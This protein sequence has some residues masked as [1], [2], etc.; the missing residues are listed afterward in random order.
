MTAAT[1]AVGT[2]QT[3]YDVRCSVALGSKADIIGSLSCA[4]CSIVQTQGCPLMTGRTLRDGNER[5][6]LTSTRTPLLSAIVI[7]PHSGLG[8]WPSAVRRED[9]AQ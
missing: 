6:P 5:P 4:D 3:I 7:S 8:G 1:S 2:K 9:N